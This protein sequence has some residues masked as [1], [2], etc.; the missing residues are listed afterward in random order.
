M[1]MEN[2]NSANKEHQTRNMGGDFSISCKEIQ[3]LYLFCL[4]TLY[5]DFHSMLCGFPGSMDKLCLSMRSLKRHTIREPRR[6]HLQNWRERTVCQK[7]SLTNRMR[8]VQLFEELLHPPKYSN[9]Y[10]GIM[11]SISDIVFPHAK[12]TLLRT[13]NLPVCI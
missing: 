9:I 3:L 7:C 5:R 12:I 1:E 4:N 13:D 2:E 6:H 11:L 8:A 10:V